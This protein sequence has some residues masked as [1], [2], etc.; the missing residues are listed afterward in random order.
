[1]ANASGR[2]RHWLLYRGDPQ[3]YSVGSEPAPEHFHDRPTIQP[4]GTSTLSPDRVARALGSLSCRGRCAA[5]FGSDG[6]RVATVGDLDGHHL[7]RLAVYG[8]RNR[9]SL[10]DILVTAR[11]GFLVVAGFSDTR[12]CRRRHAAGVALDRRV[13]AHIAVDRIL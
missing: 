11:A 6:G 8:Q 12:S 10:H 5:R 13:L 2:E 7:V 9:R 3:E 1:T 4:S